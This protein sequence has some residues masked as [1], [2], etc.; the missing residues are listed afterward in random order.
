M[1]G[2]LTGFYFVKRTPAS[3]HDVRNLFSRVR[4]RME[5]R[6]HALKLGYWPDNP[7][8]EN[9]GAVLDLDWEWVRGMPSNIRD[10]GELRIDG[11]I[12]GH[13]N[14]RIIFFR[15]DP[16]VRNPLPMIWILQVF[17]KKRDDIT[18]D[19]IISFKQRRKWVLNQFYSS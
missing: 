19:Q 13:R 11:M 12:G 5:V 2:N 14:L 16:K 3:S 17:A 7:P 15:G 9:G 8:G 4:D 10:V 6:R 18:K 1:Y